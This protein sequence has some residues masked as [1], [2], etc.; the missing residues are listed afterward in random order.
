MM[1]QA[2]GVYERCEVSSTPPL[3]YDPEPADQAPGELLGSI[4]FHQPLAAW[5]IDR[6]NFRAQP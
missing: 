2:G 5:R 4:E 1:S 3:S 6:L